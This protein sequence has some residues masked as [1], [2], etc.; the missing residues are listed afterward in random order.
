PQAFAKGFIPRSINIGIDGSFAPW[1]GALI[2]GTQQP[3]LIVAEKGREEEVITRLAR[4]GFDNTIGYLKGGFQTWPD[5]GKETDTVDTISASEFADRFKQQ[6]L[7]VIDV[8]K[9]GE[10]QAEHV[11]NASNVPLDYINQHL[12]EIPKT[13]DVYLHCAGGYRSMITASILKSRG[14][15]NL[16]DVQGGFKAIEETSVPRTDFACT[17]VKHEAPI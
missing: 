13:G 7:Y 17:K 10:F 2:P 1:V 15:N 5:A 9:P 16:I 11:K 3:L 12:S 14:W 8:R 6:K 4:V